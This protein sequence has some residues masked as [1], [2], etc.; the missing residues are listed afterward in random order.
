MV[1]RPSTTHAPRTRTAAWLALLGL[2]LAVALPA[3]HFAPRSAPALVAPAATPAAQSLSAP[4]VLRS[5]LSCPVC[6]ALSHARN[7]A[8][9][10]GGPAHIPAVAA[11]ALAAA[12]VELPPAAPDRD[13]Q[14]P[15][16]PPVPA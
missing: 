5:H 1:H 10:S 15:R 3:I 6:L 7:A 16:A 4:E 12:A 11:P 9:H 14:R 2:A 13:D 8:L